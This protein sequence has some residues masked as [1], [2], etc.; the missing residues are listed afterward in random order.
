[1]K[2]ANK[3]FSAMIVLTCLVLAACSGIPGGNNGGGSGSGS[4]GGTAGSTFTISVK[5][6]GLSGTGMVVQ[7]NGKDDLAITGNGTFPFKTKVTAYAVTV[8]T[9]PANP[10]QA[11][12]VTNGTGTAT[13][14]ATVTVACA[15]GSFTVGGQVTG[16]VGSGLVLQNNG[17]DNLT[18][19]ADGTFTFPT[20]ANLNDPYSITVLVQPTKPS[21]VCSV[22]SGSGSVTQ[23]VGTPVVACSIGTLSV[24]G[25][26]AGLAGTGLVLQNNGGDNLTINAN[27]PFSFPTLLVSGQT[28]NV[29]ILTLPTNPP[30]QCNI[31]TNTGTAT[32]PVNTVQVTCD[33]VKE[34]IGGTVVGQSIPS[35]QT[36]TMVLQNN[37]GDN[38]P[39]NGNVDFQFVTLIPY[40]NSYDVS[41]FVGPGTQDQGCVIWGYQGQAL[42]PV[43]DVTVDCGH[44]DWTWLNGANTSNQNGAFS[45]ITPPITAFIANSPGGRK[46]ASSWSD[47]QGRLWLFGGWGYT[48]NTAVGPQPFFLDEMWMYNGANDYGGS[49]FDY[50]NFISPLPPPAAPVVTPPARWGAVTWTDSSDNLWLFG[51]QTGGLA[52]LND[53]WYFNTTSKTWTHVSGGANINGVYGTQGT[54]STTNLPGGRWGSTA[55]IDPNG[56]VWLF[57]GFGYDAA[58]S[59][60]GLLNDL[61]EFNVANKTWTW[62]SGSNQTNQDGVYGTQGTAASTNVPGGRQASVS[63]LDN[64]GNFWI[65]GGYNLSG[66]G[67]P[68]SFNDLWKFAGGQWTWVNGASTVNQVGVFGLQGVS[69]ATN[70]PGSRW[71]SAAWTDA[72]GNLWLFGGQGYDVAG[73][74]SLADLW[75]YNPNASG[76][77]DANPGLPASGQ[78]VWVKG[79]SS[80]NQA[81]VYGLNPAQEFGTFWPHVTNNPGTRYGAAFWY[82]PVND[83]HLPINVTRPNQPVF[84]MFGGEGN[85]S[86]TSN[87]NGLL[88][89]LWRYLPYP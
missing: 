53:L 40:G 55:R 71:S 78:W 69:A 73:N 3:A 72:Q 7:D 21:Q 37:G 4:G 50:W 59:T 35:G 18:I 24:G 29:T 23:N 38:L 1:M 89:D 54:G 75:A 49:V 65:F 42:G 20:A 64:S 58:D 70:T 82:V 6:T 9:Q 28:Y 45:P 16:L 84:F 67:Q 12:T 57:G 11:C 26:V 19:T 2:L 56:N 76:T 46:Y 52:F 88:N 63:W 87:G 66:T 68:N 60:P 14:D 86:T 5:V 10:Q 62:I 15:A 32:A 77:P 83:S 22:A 36:S 47:S 79:S 17:K 31:S 25:S 13:A 8:K 39:V 43:T 74:G 33:V 30:Q 81:G 48:Y 80:F 27:G 61:W 85:D 51:G 41:L 44:N 34:T